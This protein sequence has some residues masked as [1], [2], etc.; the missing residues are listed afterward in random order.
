LFPSGKF[1]LE[2]SPYQQCLFRC[3][4]CYYLMDPVDPAHVNMLRM[5]SI[6]R[7]YANKLDANHFS[8]DPE[9]NMATVRGM[10]MRPSQAL[11]IVMQ[12]QGRSLSHALN[13]RRQMIVKE[14]KRK[15]E[16]RIF[17]SSLPFFRHYRIHATV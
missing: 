1:K 4:K 7:K 3:A 2:N 16:R 11:E 6:P 5:R 13:T 17:F 12:T 8:Q 15:K 10:E 9:K 14:R